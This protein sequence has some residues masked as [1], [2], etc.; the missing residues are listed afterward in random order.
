MARRMAAI[1]V[2]KTGDQY[3]IMCTGQMHHVL[4]GAFPCDYLESTQYLAFHRVQLAYQR[5]IGGHVFQV[6]NAYHDV[7]PAFFSQGVDTI[8]A[9]RDFCKLAAM[10][11]LLI[12]FGPLFINCRFAAP[13][14]FR[15]DV[16]KVDSLQR[17]SERERGTRRNPVSQ[18]RC[19]SFP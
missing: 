10:V 16:L 4:T 12:H 9:G 11:P 13:Q 18:S 6:R 2:A 19:H 5:V 1:E 7:M 17:R 3:R 8:V 15:T 14:T